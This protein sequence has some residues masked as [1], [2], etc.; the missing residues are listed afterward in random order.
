[1]T[2][3]T[4]PLRVLVVDDDQRYRS[5][6]RALLEAERFDVVG[7][8]PNGSDGVTLAEALAPD[9]V[10]MDLEMPVMNGAEATAAIC[11]TDDHPVVVIVSGSKSSELLPAALAAGARWHVAKGHVPEELAPVLQAIGA[12]RRR[13]T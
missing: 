8:A 12:A 1:M 3:T 9:V 11:A 5:A 7:E 13:P 6:L 4:A 10:T 2:S